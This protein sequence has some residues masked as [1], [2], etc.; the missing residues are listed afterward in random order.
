MVSRSDRNLITERADSRCEY[1]RA[2]QVVTGVTF[3][4]EHIVPQTR[5]GTNE[6][7]NYALACVTCNGHKSDW[8]TGF[9]PRTGA[10][11]PLFHPRRDRWL[12]HFRFVAENCTIEGITVKG[13]ATVHRLK[14][15]E[16]K[17]VEARHLWVQLDLF[18]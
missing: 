6:Q 2:P 13:R 8:V 17:Q 7:G 10:E 9:D 11:A 16:T 5:G 18:P 4:V 12:R 15:N 14:M 1:C 3:H